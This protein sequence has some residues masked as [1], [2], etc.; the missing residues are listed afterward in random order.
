MN[1][2]DLNRFRF[3]SDLTFMCFFQNGLGQNYARY[4]GR[5]AENADSHLT[6]KSLLKTM[7]QVLELHKANAVQPDSKYEPRSKSSFTPEEI[8]PMKSMMAK[9]K[10]KCI[11]CHDVKNARLNHLSNLGKLKK[12]MVFTYPSPKRIGIAIDRDDQSLIEK[13]LED[14]PAAESGLKAGDRIAKVD[15]QRVLTFGDFTRVLEMSPETGKLPIEVLRGGKKERVDLELVEDWRKNSADP[16]WRA[17]TDS[18]GPNSGFWGAKLEDGQKKKLK[19]EPEELA[20]KVKFIWGQWARKAKIRNGDIVV[21]INGQENDMTIRQL[22]G[23]L[24]MNLDY[25][26]EIP[27]EVMRNGKRVRLKMK[28]PERRQH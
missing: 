20:V 11:H 13:I 14:S 10:E 18:V 7:N 5:E 3:E 22:Q 8:L 25:E 24:Q 6:Q 4:G 23:Y 15:G 9:R 1:G 27:L 28:L 21:S 2:V 16:S 26:D 17:S 19:I 12:D